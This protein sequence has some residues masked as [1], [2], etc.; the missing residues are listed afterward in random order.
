MARICIA[1]IVPPDQYSA[2]Q[3]TGELALHIVA[4]RVLTF[5]DDPALVGEERAYRLVE[6]GAIVIADDG[7]ISWWGE[8]AQL[9]EE[10]RALPVTDH[11]HRLVMP[12]FIDAHLHFPQYRMIAAYGKDLLDWLNRY[13]FIEEQRYADPAISRP[14]AHAFLDEL[15]RNGITSCLAFS[16][17]HPQALDALFEAALERNV[18]LISGKTMM[19]CNAPKGLSDTPERGY[20]ES[21]E[22]IDRWHGIGRLQYAISPRFAVTSSEGQLEATGALRREHPDLV[23]QTHLS[24]NTAEIEAVARA[25]PL[26]RDYTDAYDRHGLLG[27]KSFFA[28]GI[29]LSERE[30]ARLSESGSS[31]VH[32]PT[33]NNF[34]GSGL[35]RWRHARE[36]SRPVGVAVGCDIGG[37]TSFSMLATL[38]DAYVVSQLAGA[39]ISAFDAFFAATLGNARLLHLDHEIGAIETGKVAD[40]VVL[41]PRATPIMAARDALSESLH[42]TLFSLTIMGDDRAVAETYVAGKPAKSV[43]AP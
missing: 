38:R 8:R 4:G 7:T 30:L 36:A 32:C 39:R 29:H 17:V 28:H 43:L 37:G 40:L 16:T 24:E 14:A 22:L 5:L 13:T 2:P 23:L 20:R 18:A 10:Y 21:K 9:P 12:G 33:S 11:G 3:Q 31:I 1:N 42:D 15:A 34:L 35:F 27:E 19:D 41:D 25:F 6:R 26:S